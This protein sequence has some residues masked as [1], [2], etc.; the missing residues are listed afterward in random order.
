MDEQLFALGG[1]PA[2]IRASAKTWQT[3]SLEST[4]ASA[5]LAGIGAVSAASFLGDEGLTHADHLRT[6]L[7]P[8]LA[9]MGEAW[10]CV[11]TALFS[12]AAVLDDCQTE[13]R[14]LAT[15]S[16]QDSVAVTAS[17]ISLPLRTPQMPQTPV[18][19]L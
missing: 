14:R 7:G 16:A 11:S 1:D 13:L 10:S 18:I 4:M 3:F 9:R 19:S 15:T 12:Y 6:E 8:R 17:T 2:A 5:E